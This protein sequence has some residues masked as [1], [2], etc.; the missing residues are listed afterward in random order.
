MDDNM[1]LVNFEHYCEHCVNKEKSENEE[2][3]DICLS[4]PARQYSHRP[5]KFVEVSNER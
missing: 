1:K 2:P 5:E 4:I 3:C